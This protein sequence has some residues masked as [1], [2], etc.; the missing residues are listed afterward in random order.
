M[1]DE[2]GAGTG[3]EK[4]F[5]SRSR[6]PG[7]GHDDR[8]RDDRHG[9]RRND[10]YDDRR[11][12]R[13]DNRRGERDDRRGG[14]RSNRETGESTSVLVKNLNYSTSPDDIRD[15]FSKFGEVRD[16][17]LPLEYGSRRP[18]GFGFV[19]F[20]NPDDAR[21]AIREM[22]QT[23]IAG[24]KIEVIIAQQRRK[25]PE[26]MRRRGGS[27]RRGGY[28][29]RDRSRSGSR[30]RREERRRSRSRSYRRRY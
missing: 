27:D 10:R 3:G 6:S 30:G 16:V 26:S 22:D 24:N 21:G 7:R 11:G 23:E 13:F 4:R 28:G 15:H 14:Y 29:Y 5:R 2:V 18:R 25:S 8:R 9:D 1:T 20:V 17:Y 12:D 19:E